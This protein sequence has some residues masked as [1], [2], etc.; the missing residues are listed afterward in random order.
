MTQSLDSRL[1]ERA[2]RVFTGSNTL[3]TDLQTDAVLRVL[4]RGLV[5]SECIDVSVLRIIF[6]L[7]F[8]PDVRIMIFTWMI[9]KS[10]SWNTLSFEVMT[11]A[12]GRV[13]KWRR[14][15]LAMQVYTRAVSCLEMKLD[16]ADR[17]VKR[18]CYLW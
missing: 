6:F 17:Q 14:I 8:A 9:D 12:K 11:P 10:T 16:T 2:F 18:R 1:R 4:Q 13:T 5:D 7:S 3:V 15:R